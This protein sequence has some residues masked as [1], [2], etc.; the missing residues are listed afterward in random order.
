MRANN[1]L[2]N[3]ILGLIT[4]L[5]VIVIWVYATS[6]GAVPS[7]LLPTLSMVK[8]AFVDMTN[9]GQL[10]S[11]LL[12]SLSRVVKG[13]L[14]AAVLGIVLGTVMGMSKTICVML[15]P[16]ITTIRQIPM[17]AWFPL[18]ILWCGIGELSKVVI[19]VLAA[20]FPVLVNTLSG[21]QSTPEG[22]IEVARLYKLSRWQRFVKLYLP[23]ALPQILVGLKLG[24]GV[25]WM[26]VVAS[27]LVAAT[28]GIGY[29]MNDARSMMRSDKVIVC[30]IVIGIVGVLMDKLLTI[31]FGYITPWTKTEKK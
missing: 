7:S 9:S 22:Y 3:I 31:L 23:H 19:I 25:S 13:F 11:D 14:T 24:L 18:I 8:D 6:S 1:L 2:K 17:I 30:M 28:S 16:T 27:E 29:R 26:A 21:I 4:P 5:V 10:Q 15:Q 12:L 20:F